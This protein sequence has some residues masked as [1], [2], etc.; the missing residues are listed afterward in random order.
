M[1]EENQT[2]VEE[3]V[4]AAA[5]GREGSTDVEHDT[6]HQTTKGEVEEEVEV[7]E[8]KAAGTDEAGETAR[9]PEGPGEEVSR[10]AIAHIREKS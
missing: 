8:E 9:E 1:S 4:T 10:P 5:E 2:E 6:G 3:V 7:G